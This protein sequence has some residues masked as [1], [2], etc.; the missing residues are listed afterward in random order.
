[1]RGFGKRRRRFEQ[2]LD[3]HFIGIG[4]LVAIGPE[5]FDAIVVEGIV[6]GRDHHAQ[7]GAH[8]LR[9]HR[10]CRRRHRADLHHVH[11]DTG[12][13]RDQCIFEHI[14][15]QARILADHDAMFVPAAQEM[16]ARRHADAHRHF[17]GHRHLVGQAPDPVG[18]E[19]LAH[20]V[21]AS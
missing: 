8:R 2:C 21:S 13:P 12:E 7:I 15:R 14:A 19:K 4:Q 18:S 20:A 17:G 5:Q 1:M 11:A 3:L 6:A 10:H 16:R 9:Q